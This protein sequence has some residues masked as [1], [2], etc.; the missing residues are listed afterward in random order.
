MGIIK[1]GANIVKGLGVDTDKLPKEIKDYLLDRANKK[2]Q[3][4]QSDRESFT[5]E[6]E[7]LSDAD[8]MIYVP[9]VYQKSIYKIDY[10]KLKAK[11]VKL[12]SFDIDDTIDDSIWNKARGILSGVKVSMPKDAK[13]LFRDL[14]SMGFTVTLLTNTSAGIAKDVCDDL[15]ADGYFA[16]ADKPETRS[17]ERMMAENDV[18][19]S[20]VAHV[21]N[22]IRDDIVGGN[23]AG[24]TTCLVRRAGYSLK[25]AKFISKGLGVP[26]KGHLIRVRLLERGL[27]RKHHKEVKGDQYYQLGELPKYQ[28]TPTS[29]PGAQ[30]NDIKAAV[31]DLV[32][33]VEADR[34]KTYTLEE[35]Q[36][37][38]YKN[39]ESAGMKTL[40]THLGDDIVFTGV[41][42][43]AKDGR[44][45]EESELLDGEL[46]GYEFT[47]GH[48]TIRGSLCLYQDDD[49]VHYTE[50]VPVSWDVITQYLQ[51][52]GRMFGRE[53]GSR[54]VQVISARYNGTGAEGWRHICLATTSLSWE[55][56]IDFIGTLKL[57]AAA[58]DEQE[59]LFILKQYTGNAYG[60]A[61]WYKL[62]SDGTVTEY[63]EHPYDPES[64]EESWKDVD[65]A[66]ESG[67][68]VTTSKE[69]KKAIEERQDRIIITGKLAKKVKQAEKIKKLSPAVLAMI[70][71]LSAAGAAALAA[72]PVVTVAVPGVGGAAALAAFAATAAPAATASGL[73]IPVLLVISV[74]GLAA[75]SILFDE[76]THI[77]MEAGK[78]I[79][80]RKRKDKKDKEQL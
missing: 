3:E 50:R 61:H 46:F 17:F 64:Y 62:S 10:G 2:I 21:G 24:V 79:F 47:I 39:N 53:N 68:T 25:V 18:T 11:G 43:D 59:L 76:Y 32:G 27:W 51:E 22:S 63:E 29:A 14:K 7:Q 13:E 74:V 36:R 37:N 75:M 66:N 65:T 38:V 56:D 5:A 49:T 72:A 16:R 45:L 20:Q 54:E 9:D 15:H 23:R 44:D 60:V 33:K 31:A 58:P 80:E 67:I 4:E 52:G 48:Y 1:K 55:E 12:I 57:S 77:D 30:E 69:L 40:R 34:D 41:W 42:A 70:G 35:L 8:L 26:T 6:L 71:G 28:T 78:L 73:S 19:P